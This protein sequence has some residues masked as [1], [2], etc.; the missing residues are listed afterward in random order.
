MPPPLNVIGSHQRA[1]SARP[2][3]LRLSDR[4]LLSM[5]DDNVAEPE[6]TTVLQ[7]TEAT[8]PPSFTLRSVRASGTATSEISISTQNASM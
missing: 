8:G 3:P 7:W 5:A 1:R 2:L 4:C 6:V